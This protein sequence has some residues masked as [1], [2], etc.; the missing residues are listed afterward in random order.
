MS[1]IM[2]DYDWF[3]FAIIFSA[4]LIKTIRMARILAWS[5]MGI[6]IKKSHRWFSLTVQVIS[7]SSSFILKSI[8]NALI[9]TGCDY[10]DH[11][12]H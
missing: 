11:D 7:N 9:I 8:N 3:S 2:T 6:L 4:L 10:N 12:R 5:K 1:W